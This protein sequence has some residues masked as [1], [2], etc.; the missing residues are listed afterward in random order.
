MPPMGRM[1]QPKSSWHGACELSALQCGHCGHIRTPKSRASTT[2]TLTSKEAITA[3]GS[4]AEIS[5]RTANEGMRTTGSLIVG[6]NRGD[7][8]PAIELNSAACAGGTFKI[9]S[10]RLYLDK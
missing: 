1:L 7:A 5:L 3:S 9:G 2:L 8:R 4:L 6:S 10:F